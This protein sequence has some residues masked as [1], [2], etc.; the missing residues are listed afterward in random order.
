MWLG[1]ITPYLQ[2]STASSRR[3]NSPVWRSTVRA[4]VLNP[5][6]PKGGGSAAVSGYIR[7]GNF[8]G[9]VCTETMAL[10]MHFQKLQFTCWVN[11]M[12]EFQEH[13]MNRLP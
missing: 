6:A 13:K 10:Y 9:N 11:F 8:Q 7:V 3:D 1:V 5:K 2:V 12:E 4:V